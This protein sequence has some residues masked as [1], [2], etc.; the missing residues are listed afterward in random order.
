MKYIIPSVRASNGFLHWSNPIC[1]FGKKRENS[2]FEII[3]I[4]HPSLP[5]KLDDVGQRGQ[6]GKNYEN[7]SSSKRKRRD[8]GNNW[9][10]LIEGH[11]D[12]QFRPAIIVTRKRGEG[13]SKQQ[14]TGGR[15]PPPINWSLVRRAFYYSVK[16]EAK[17]REQADSGVEILRFTRFNY[18][19]IRG[20][21]LLFAHGWMA[22]DPWIL[23]AFRPGSTT[24]GH[25]ATGIS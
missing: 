23:Q 14:E 2:S 1:N 13:V 18:P 17:R 25:T 21:G 4:H 9:F 8:A 10:R 22:T 5:G 11:P 15:P 7:R 24:L 3:I 16:R 12:E 20:S 6:K 19:V